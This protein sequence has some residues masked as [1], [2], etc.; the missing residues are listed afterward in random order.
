MLACCD[1]IIA[2]A[3]STIAMGGPAMIEGGGL[4]VRTHKRICHTQSELLTDRA[5]LARSTR[6]KRSDRLASKCPTESWTFS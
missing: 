5:M 4:G 3:N 2:T 1:V 6:Q